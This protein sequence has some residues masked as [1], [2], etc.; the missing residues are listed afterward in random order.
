MEQ[1]VRTLTHLHPDGLL[2]GIAVRSGGT[3]ELHGKPVRSIWALL[4][5]LY[6]QRVSW[7]RLRAT[8]NAG[9]KVLQL[10]QPVD[11]QE[12][13]SVVIASTEIPPCPTNNN[14]P[15]PCEGFPIPDQ[16]E[17]RVVESVSADGRDVTLKT[18][19][20]YKH[21]GEWPQQAEVGLLTRQDIQPFRV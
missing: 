13:D 3:L 18:I 19:L 2:T 11:W 4:L 15:P 10:Q 17:V 20:Q 5:T 14:I 16:T 7:T 6:S 9:T 21:W 8:A 12:G 1:N